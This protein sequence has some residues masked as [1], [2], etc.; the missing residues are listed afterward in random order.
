MEDQTGNGEGRLRRVPLAMSLL[1]GPGQLRTFVGGLTVGA[2]AAHQCFRVAAAASSVA[3]AAPPPAASA[4][5]A[6]PAAAEPAASSAA[7]SEPEPAA[8]P[9]RAAAGAAPDGDADTIVQYVVVRKDLSKSLGWTVGP[10]MAQACHASCA[11]LWLSRESSTTQAY[12]AESALDDMTKV[13]MEIKN[14]GQLLKLAQQ[15]AD[16]GVGHKLWM[17]KPEDIP[18]AL[19]TFPVY[20]SS[21]KPLFKKCQLY[22][23]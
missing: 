16:A 22:K 2:V 15:L 20:R 9:A 19:A 7:S 8:A 3:A 21:T 4:A 23:G 10:I 17:E 1:T 13:T 11:A 6:G 5:A 14:E 18:T 12:C